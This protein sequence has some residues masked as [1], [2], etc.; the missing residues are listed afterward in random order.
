[1]RG[2]RLYPRRKI[3]AN[4]FVALVAAPGGA[5]PNFEEK[6]MSKTMITGGG[7]LRIDALDHLGSIAAIGSCDHGEACPD[8]S[9]APARELIAMRC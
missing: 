6:Q 7:P 3:V 5:Q 8:H 9:P 2:T 1:M 4:Q